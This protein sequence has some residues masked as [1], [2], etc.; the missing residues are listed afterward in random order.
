M[1]DRLPAV[2][3]IA[4]SKTGK[5]TYIEKLIPA[6][7]RRGLRIVAA[8]HDAHSFQMDREGKDTDRLRRSGARRVA[9]A[10]DRELA[11]YGDTDPDLTLRRL[12]DRYLGEAD[13]LIAEGFREA[14]VPQ[15][16]L[17]RR[18]AAHPPYDPAAEKVIAVVG[19]FRLE[20]DRPHFPLDDPEPFVDWL[21]Q[22][23]AA[24]TRRRP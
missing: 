9:I 6:L 7:S 13:L 21:L 17:C 16:V 19:D 23:L 2:A 4:P 10:N 14:D 5:T 20:T 11:V 3:F 1:A 22:R 18:E 8:K 24:P 15:V 12:A